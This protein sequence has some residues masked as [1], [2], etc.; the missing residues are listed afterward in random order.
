[1]QHYAVDTILGVFVSILA[2]ACAIYLLAIEKSYLDERYALQTIMQVM[3]IR[4][5]AKAAAVKTKES[6]W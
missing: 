3:K 4:F 5:P 1:M 2:I 6:H